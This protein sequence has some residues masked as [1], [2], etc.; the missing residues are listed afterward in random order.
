MYQY[1]KLIFLKRYPKSVVLE[2]DFRAVSRFT[3]HIDANKIRAVLRSLLMLVE[4]RIKNEQKETN[5]ALLY[6]AW[7]SHETHYAAM[8]VSYCKFVNTYIEGKPKK[9]YIKSLVLLPKSPMAKV[10]DVNKDP[11][12]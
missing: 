3:C 12:N 11:E 4:D 1:L 10:T 2:K 9:E 5:G 7:T 6:D 8:I